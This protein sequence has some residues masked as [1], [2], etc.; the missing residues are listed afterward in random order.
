[1]AIYQLFEQIKQEEELKEKPS[2][3]I[4]TPPPK[5]SFFASFMT[6]LS[7]FILLGASLLWC[8]FALC[9]LGVVLGLQT[10]FLGKNRRIQRGL[11]G[12]FRSLCRSLVCI[13]SLVIGLFCPS[14]GMIVACTYFMMYDKAGIEEVIPKPLQAQF[15]QFFE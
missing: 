13:V 3:Q 12:A 8:G 5:S 14:F 7:F 11:K 15:Y 2:V 1:M 4:L 10:L 9:Q 6:R